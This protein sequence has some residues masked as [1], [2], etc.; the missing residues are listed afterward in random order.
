MKVTHSTVSKNNSTCH[1]MISTSF[2]MIQHNIKLISFSTWRSRNHPT[3][4]PQKWTFKVNL[5][6]N[7]STTMCNIT[8][9]LWHLH[10]IAE[11]IWYVVGLIC[12]KGPLKAS[13]SFIEGDK[14]K[15]LAK[16]LDSTRLLYQFH[17]KKRAKPSQKLVSVDHTYG[18]FLHRS[19]IAKNLREKYQPLRK[20]AH[21]F[22]MFRFFFT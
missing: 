8:I 20:K 18:E 10:C 22:L 3:P 1:L 17:F 11:S 2:I 15:F 21:H 16:N 9:Q 7:S 14:M 5:K 12:P 6:F 19:L 13:L 4:T